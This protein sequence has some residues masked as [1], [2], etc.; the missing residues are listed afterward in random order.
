MPTQARAVSDSSQGPCSLKFQ[1]Q[2]AFELRVHIAGAPELPIGDAE[3]ACDM[4]QVN[5]YFKEQ[6]PQEP[7]HRAGRVASMTR[8]GMQESS[9][10][11]LMLT[12]VQ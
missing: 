8:S 9:G 4:A 3:T 10:Y 11:L 2:E 7:P 6:S 5:G 1:S 12:L